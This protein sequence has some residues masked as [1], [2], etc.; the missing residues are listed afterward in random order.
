MKLI[1]LFIL[2][3]FSSNIFAAGAPTFN[4]LSQSDVSLVSKEFASN[5]THT[6]L[7]PASS[8]GKIWGLEFGIM[9]GLTK[10]P[11]IDRLSKSFSSTSNISSMPTA[12]LIGG[13]TLPFGINAELN[14]IPQVNTSSVYLKNMAYA[15]KWEVTSAIPTAPFNFAV[16][17]HGNSGE[18]GYSG[19]INNASTGN[20][21]VNATT[22]WKNTSSGYNLEISK[23]YLFIEP[24]FGYGHISTTTNIGVTGSANISIFTFSSASSYKSE[25]S[26]SHMFAGLNLNLLLIK[27]GAEYAQIMGIKKTVAKVSFYF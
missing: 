17:V 14:M 27:V 21:N 3:L 18:L 20:Q 9:G 19:V 1:P 6:I 24:Y 5:F 4:S 8:L 22:S 12:G 11:E 23:K 10:T 7:A 16:R 2:C 25:N 13:V 26:G 15:L